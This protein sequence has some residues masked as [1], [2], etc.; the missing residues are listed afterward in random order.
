MGLQHSQ[1]GTLCC[2]VHAHRQVQAHKHIKVQNIH[3]LKHCSNICGDIR[4]CTPTSVSKHPKPCREP[5]HSQMQKHVQ[6]PQNQPYVYPR[7]E[8][9]CSHREAPRLLTQGPTEP[10]VNIPTLPQTVPEHTRDTQSRVH[11]GKRV[12]VLVCANCLITDAHTPN[13]FISMC[14]ECTHTHAHAHTHMLFSSGLIF[15]FP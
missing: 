4:I 12:C 5:R 8:V 3:M 13:I 7:K 2:Q 6:T 10:Q 9:L 11:S 15:L 1:A 14:P